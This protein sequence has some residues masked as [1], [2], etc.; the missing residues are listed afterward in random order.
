MKFYGNRA[1]LS[2]IAALLIHAQ[3]RCLK[4]KLFPPGQEVGKPSNQY[5]RKS[6]MNTKHL[7]PLVALVASAAVASAQSSFTVS[8]DGPQA[9]T[10]SA[11]TGSGMLTLNLDNTVSYDITFSGLSGNTT[12]AHI[13]GPA[14][15][16]VP[17]G[18][19]QGLSF[20]GGAGSTSGQLQGTT[21]A[22]TASQVTALLDG[23]TYV[24][25]HSTVNPGGEIRGQIYLIPEPATVSLAALGG[26]GLFVWRSRRRF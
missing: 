26:L 19:I 23:M 20:V 12:A 16:G 4:A 2:G 3:P 11:G 9:G 5:N 1:G 18:V 17:A 22:F 15:V 7:I 10:A 13:H 6:V 25:I 8:I 21:G 24:N 14:D